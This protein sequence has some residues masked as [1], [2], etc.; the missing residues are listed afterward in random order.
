MKFHTNDVSTE[1]SVGG[2]YYQA[3]LTVEEGAD[4]LDCD[5]QYLV[6]QRDLEMLHDDSCYLAT[7]DERYCGHFR[8]RRIEFAPERLAI[9]LDRPLDN[10]NC[11]TFRLATSEFEEASHVIKIISGEI[12][13]DSE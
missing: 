4:E 11:V 5:G 7:H 3:A 12:E 2:D 8:L 1:R 13:P 6:I 9:E 10:L